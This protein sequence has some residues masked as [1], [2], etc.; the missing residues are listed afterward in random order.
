MDL[1]TETKNVKEQIATTMQLAVGTLSKVTGLAPET[2]AILLA[3]F[4]MFQM[5]HVVPDE[6]AAYVK[7]VVTDY[8]NNNKPTDEVHELRDKFVDAF[9]EKVRQ[10]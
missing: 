7:Q 4:M 1:E 6:Y 3:D 8:P 10:G 5:I 2:V 9:I